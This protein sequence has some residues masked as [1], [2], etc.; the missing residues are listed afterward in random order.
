VFY[1]LLI[2][3]RDRRVLVVGGGEV[4]ERKVDSLL[5]PGA[6]VTVVAPNLTERLQTL[7]DAKS[8]QVHRRRFEVSDL[9]GMLFVISATDEKHTQETVAAAARDRNILVNTVDTPALCDFIVPAVIRRGDV[10]VAISTSGKSPALSAALRAK[11]EG[12]VTPD[13][14]RAARIL[15]EI[16]KE[17]HE[18]FALPDQR[19]DAFEHIVNSGILDWIAESDDQTA[20]KRVRG[21]IEKLS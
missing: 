13:T 17:V 4:A 10:V 5:E 9:E 7:A 2:D 11:L 20:L 21:I 1:P 18:R 3:L 8:I 12:V 14:A 15:G 19:K 6:N 16:R